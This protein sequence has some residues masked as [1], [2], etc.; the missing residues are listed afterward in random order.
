MGTAE[1]KGVRLNTYFWEHLVVQGGD[2]SSSTPSPK[3]RR[4]S[5]KTPP[6]KNEH[7]EKDK[8]DADKRA[9]EPAPKE[10]VEP[11]TPK[12]ARVDDDEDLCTP[13]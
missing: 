3:R 9:M 8:E 1:R 4:L 12:V 11:S 7:K 6:S 13:P 5:V 2:N 10:K